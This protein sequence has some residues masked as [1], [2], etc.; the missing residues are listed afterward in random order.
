MSPT[1]I[2]SEDRFARILVAAFC[3]D[4]RVTPPTFG[5]KKLNPKENSGPTD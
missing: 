5:T 2:S 4:T 1:T 3:N